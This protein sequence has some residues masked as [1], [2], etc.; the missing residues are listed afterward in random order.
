MLI[1]TL[2]VV[3]VAG[4]SGQVKIRNTLDQREFLQ[5]VVLSRTDKELR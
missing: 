1:E 5:G 3:Y 2:T 4:D